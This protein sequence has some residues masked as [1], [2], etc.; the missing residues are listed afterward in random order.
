MNRQEKI[1]QISS[2]AIRDIR[3]KSLAEMYQLIKPETTEATKFYNS[4]V[5]NVISSTQKVLST[6]SLIMH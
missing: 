1:A 3:G 2:R 4:I 6:E 5:Y